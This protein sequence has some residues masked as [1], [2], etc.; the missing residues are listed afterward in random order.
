M[1]TWKMKKKKEKEEKTDKEMV[2]ALMKQVLEE[3]LR[4]HP[5][6]YNQPKKETNE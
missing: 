4:L 5:E 3:Q 1:N 6:I 2:D